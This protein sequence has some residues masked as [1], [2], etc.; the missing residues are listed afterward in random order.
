M[1]SLLAIGECML[2]LRPQRKALGPLTFDSAFGGDVYNA[3]VYAKRIHPKLD[4]RFFSAVGQDSLSESMVSAWAEQGI[5]TNYV[6]R[7]WDKTIGM[8]AINTDHHGERSFSY[9]RSEAAARDMVSRHSVEQ[10]IEI[11]APVDMV[12]FSGIT[13]A[14]L[15]DHHRQ[16]LL[17]VLT[18]LRQQGST[19]AF[20]PNYRERLWDN[21]QQAKTWLTRAYQCSDIALPGADEHELLFQHQDLETIT[22]F[23]VQCGCDE[24]VVKQGEQGTMAFA[25]TQ[26]FHEPFVPAERQV[27][28]TAAGDSFA[29]SYLASRLSGLSVLDSLSQAVTVAREVVQCPGAIM[30]P[31]EFVQRL[32]GQLVCLPNQE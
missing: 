9:W 19:I 20:D 5:N 11:L 27:D 24:V 23:C 2:E 12:F 28:S 7:L 14:I 29:G 6:Q 16:K 26:W 30:E 3:L 1:T 32:Q 10:L 13:L 22:A 21:Q 17:Q 4:C 15:S 8:Y 18:G 25:G 31:A